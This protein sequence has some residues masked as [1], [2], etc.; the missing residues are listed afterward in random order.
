MK[1]FYLG[2]ATL[3][4]GLALMMR[5]NTVSG[6][7]QSV[8]SFE[9]VQIN[10]DS[11]KVENLVKELKKLKP[12]RTTDFEAKFKKEINGFKLTEVKAFEDPET[13]SFASAN[14]AK[15]GGNIYLMITDGAGPGSEQVKANLLNYLELKEIYTPEDKS[16]VKNYKGWLVSFDWSMFE[17]DGMTS[18]QYLEG[19][20]YAVVASANQVPIEELENFLNSFGL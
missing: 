9:N 12:I 3:G 15:D 8:H 10:S 1:S 5:Y 17:S 4:V 20:R 19:N 6:H 13:G 2:M 16:A 18:I 11:T 7:Q 14:Y